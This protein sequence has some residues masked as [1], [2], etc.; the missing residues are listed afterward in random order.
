MA[1][2]PIMAGNW[3]MNLDHLQAIQVVQQ[4][5]YHLDTTDYDATD[6]VVIPP[7][8]AL[9]SI[10]TLIE[11]DRLPIGLGAQNCH[12]EAAGAFT[13]E[14]SAPMLAKLRAQYVICGHSERRTLFGDSD[15]IV[16][17]K[18]RAVLAHGMT[19]IMC[20]GE[21]EEQRTAGEQ[22]H[23]VS[24]QVTAGLHDVTG[25]QAADLVVAYE[26]IWAIGTGKTAT[27]E[28]AQVM[29]AA[30]RGVVRELY[31]GSVADSIRIQYGGSVKP[32][33]VRDLMAQADIDGALV[34][35][36]SLDP[37]DFA[38]ICRFART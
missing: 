12:W 11:G 18:V 24:G 20:V 35:G 30:V 34:G 15:E 10:Q 1:R 19:P 5:A 6:V 25:D 22:E 29:C 28:D 2:K 32:G 37:D 27:S 7:F 3:K 26:P 23:V 16:N 17:R 8:T 14:V 21:S 31:D 13:G 4:L 36:A 38:V 9:R 33:N